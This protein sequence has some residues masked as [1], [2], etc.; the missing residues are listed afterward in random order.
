M[1][2]TLLE[3]FRTLGTQFSMSRSQFWT[4]NLV[5]SICALL[6]VG[7]VVLGY[8][9]GVLNRSVVSVQNQFSQAQQLQ[10]TAQNLAVR[11][12]QAGERDAALRDLLARHEFKV[13]LRPAGP[14][15]PAP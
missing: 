2:L 13:T 15:T 6:I 8:L 5:G 12:A 9:N 4:L 1:V 14:G 3:W 11:I 10:N 7:D